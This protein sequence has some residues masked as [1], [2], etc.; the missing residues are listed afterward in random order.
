MLQFFRNLFNLPLSEDEYQEFINT[1]Q[2]AERHLWQ[3]AFKVK[4]CAN[5]TGRELAVFITKTTEI[6]TIIHEIQQLENPCENN[7]HNS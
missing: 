4:D 7:S 6:N 5:L 1:G 2:V 3:I